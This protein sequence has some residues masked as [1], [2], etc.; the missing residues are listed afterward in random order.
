MTQFKF[1]GGPSRKRRR[2][3]EPKPAPATRE[4]TR[5]TRRDTTATKEQQPAQPV[6]QPPPSEEQQPQETPL[7]P[8]YTTADAAPVVSTPC[9]EDD[10]DLDLFLSWPTNVSSFFDLGSAFNDPSILLN[11]VDF[12]QT[13]SPPS[14]DNSAEIHNQFLTEPGQPGNI[15][16]YA[17]TTQFNGPPKETTIFT[18]AWKRLIARCTP[19]IHPLL[20]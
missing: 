15:L 4:S 6:V 7:P 8:P 19:P 17:D 18:D 10:H 9:A 1:V 14:T 2:R 16:F 3:N 5:T 13:L 20:P 12:T 11:Q